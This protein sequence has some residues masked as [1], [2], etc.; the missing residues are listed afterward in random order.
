MTA[1]EQLYRPTLNNTILKRGYAREGCGFQNKNQ[2]K[3]NR[4]LCSII[5]LG[6][7]LNNIRQL[8]DRRAFLSDCSGRKT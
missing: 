4:K 1:A 8:K 5:S 2:N 3:T 6:L 7:G